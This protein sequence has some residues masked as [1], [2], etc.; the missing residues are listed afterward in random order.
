[1][2]CTVCRI[3]RLKAEGLED[4][5]IANLGDKSERKLNP[6]GESNRDDMLEWTWGRTVGVGLGKVRPSFF[7]SWSPPFNTLSPPK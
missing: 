3:H 7:P 4:P 6:K 5:L 2:Q 1:M